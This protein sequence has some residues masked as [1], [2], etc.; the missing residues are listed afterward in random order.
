MP[1]NKQLNKPTIQED[2]K[3][4]LNLWVTR[5]LVLTVIVMS[6]LWGL[7]AEMYK[8]DL[9]RTLMRLKKLEKQIT[10]QRKP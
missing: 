6:L 4:T 2:H 3:A 8:K 1:M 10:I 9:D 7:T 5:A